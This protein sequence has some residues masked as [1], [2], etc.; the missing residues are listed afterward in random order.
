[1]NKETEK[2]NIVKKVCAELGVTQK[3]LAK[4]LDVLPTAVSNWA[5][6]DIPKM[7]KLSLEQIIET[8]DLIKQL[9][10]IA[11]SVKIWNWSDIVTKYRLTLH[12]G[13]SILSTDLLARY[14]LSLGYT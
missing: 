8:K 11:Y 14:I 1:M 2:I 5:N 4:M 13:F 12:I 7:A 3:E 9:K 6:G 10:D